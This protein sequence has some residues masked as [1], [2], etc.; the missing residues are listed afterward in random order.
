[1]IAAIDS[2]NELTRGDTLFWRSLTWVVLA[3]SLIFII[4]FFA[5]VGM[6]LQQQWQRSRLKGWLDD[7]RVRRKQRAIL[8]L[9]AAMEAER[10]R[11]N[12]IITFSE[13]RR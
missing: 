10:R 9:Q 1:M 11:L 8:E 4:T 12:K 5:Q 13:G 6:A 3:I 2:I 7:L